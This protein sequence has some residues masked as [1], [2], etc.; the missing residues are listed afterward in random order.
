[1]PEKNFHS[2]ARQAISRLVIGAVALAILLALISYEIY[3]VD[4][5]S[6][7][8]SDAL[9][10]I[11]F[12]VI[13]PLVV[14]VILMVILGRWMLQSA[15]RVR[16]LQEAVE[17]FSEQHRVTLGFVR[18]LV[19]ARGQH[20]DEIAVVADA[21]EEMADKMERQ[22]NMRM[23]EQAKQNLWA[24]V[25]DSSLDAMV[26]AA[27]DRRLLT[28]NQAFTR[29]TGYTEQEVLGSEL[30][31]S[32]VH[33]PNETPLEKVWQMVEEKDYWAG[34][35][36]DKR[37][38]G[39]L[40][41]RWL[42]LSVVRDEGRKIVNYIA[43]FKDITEQKESEARFIY[44][45]NHD[46]LTGLPNRHLLHDRLARAIR[47]AER[48]QHKLALLF[49][50]LD[51]FKWVNDSLGHA[52]GDQ[53]LISVSQRLQASVR[54]SD[55]VARLGGDE[56]VV[57]LQQPSGHQ[58]LGA[59][60]EKLIQAIEQ[61][62]FLGGYDFHT[63]SS[64]GISLYPEDGQEAEILLKH[65]DTAMYAAKAGGKSGFRFFDVDMNR[66]AMARVE[67]E[68][69]L[70]RGIQNQEFEMYYQP[71][72]CL[73]SNR[74][75]G[76]EALIRWQH[77][78]YGTVLPDYFIPVAEE[79]A[80]IIPLGEWVIRAV[81]EQVVVWERMG[82]T[83]H[84]VAVNLS[85]LQVESD[86]FVDTVEQILLE[87]GTAA[88]LIEFELTESMVLRN[89]TRSAKVLQRLRKLGIHLA[90]D[91]FGTGYSS[92]SYLKQLPLDAIKIDRSFIQN[93]PNSS[94]D[95]QIVR[96]IVAL[97]KSAQMI[98]V[99]E[100]V[101]TVL[102]RDSLAA[103]GCDFL[104]GFLFSPPVPRR[105][106]EEMLKKNAQEFAAVT[107]SGCHGPSSSHH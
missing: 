58:E 66:Q 23:R 14:G 28:A 21:L 42:S 63:T 35:L 107:C 32:T 43:V 87:T 22:E 75:C 67:V 70:R 8:I 49:L 34:E 57:L 17:H 96:M 52:T 40:Y 44:Q 61:P 13:T 55:T 62:I 101:E 69:D 53:L 24:Q 2:I 78:R 103:L 98:V 1:M 99:A 90:L 25:F 16:A 19:R 88:K 82:I 47:L 6:W 73:T 5:H 102:Q 97:G 64:I 18:A 79:T 74:L 9:E 27:R 51:N 106:I 30:L 100:G 81:C 50:D 33:I 12:L 94:E 3:N 45:A 83:P 20:R 76:L 46:R 41:P 26:I 56:F 11:G 72:V 105:E 93:I 29:I 95:N 92:L 85:I 84:R 80:L 68:R 91:D 59:I 48:N 86:A 54:S 89:P 77:P 39:A 60:A 71:K 104:Q 10:W 36:L 7:P 31:A 37:K 4:G 15:R 65:A 38:D